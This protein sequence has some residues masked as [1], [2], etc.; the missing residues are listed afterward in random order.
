VWPVEATSGPRRAA[1]STRK[2]AA[3]FV[4]DG[5]KNISLRYQGQPLSESPLKVPPGK[6]GTSWQL[7]I[8]TNSYDINLK[9]KNVL[10][11]KDTGRA[12]SDGELV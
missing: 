5:D 10:E 11:E 9:V 3:F 6:S 12:G 4:G 2:G 7:K 1:H 8:E